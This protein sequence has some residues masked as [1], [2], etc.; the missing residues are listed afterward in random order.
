MKVFAKAGWFRNLKEDS[1]SS[2]ECA[3]DSTFYSHND[4]QI[5]AIRE[6]LDQHDRVLTLLLSRAAEKGVLTV[7]DVQNIIGRNMY[8]VEA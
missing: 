6:R 7:E 8:R 5:C 3:L 4:D 1:E 2:L